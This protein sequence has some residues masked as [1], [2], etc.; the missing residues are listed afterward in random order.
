M[1][2]WIPLENLQLVYVNIVVLALVVFLVL[3]LGD[4]IVQVVHNNQCDR[5]IRQMQDGR[6]RVD[7]CLDHDCDGCAEGLILRVLQRQMMDEGAM[8]EI[9]TP[10]EHSI[11]RHLAG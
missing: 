10:G 5:M 2:D 1:I 11:L 4:L 8:M 3:F 7:F 9:L 6:F